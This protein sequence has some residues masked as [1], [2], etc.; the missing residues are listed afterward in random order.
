MAIVKLP[1]CTNSSRSVGS[2]RAAT[3]DV[4]DVLFTASS[5]GI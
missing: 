1:L 4:D 5:A 2:M 3:I